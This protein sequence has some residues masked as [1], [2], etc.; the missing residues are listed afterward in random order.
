MAMLA[1]RAARQSLNPNALWLRRSGLCQ[2]TS[3]SSCV[4][5]SF[6]RLYSAMLKADHK[7]KMSLSAFTCIYTLRGHGKRAWRH[8]SKWT[9]SLISLFQVSTDGHRATCSYE[10]CF[11][12]RL[13]ILYS[14]SC[15]DALHSWGWS[16]KTSSSNFQAWKMYIIMKM[17][18]FK[19]FF[20]TLHVAMKC[21]VHFYLYMEYT[22]RPAC[23]IALLWIRCYV[24]LFYLNR[25]LPFNKPVTGAMTTC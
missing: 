3:L 25:S 7:K 8:V 13:P 17:L 4:P 5:L 10:L 2:W 11:Q 23:L 15:W 12:L 19:G 20:S 22:S 21:L 9:W 18:Y 24:P 1:E 6:S 14:A 16:D